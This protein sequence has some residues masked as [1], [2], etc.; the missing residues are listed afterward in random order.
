MSSL[1]LRLLRKGTKLNAGREGLVRT[2]KRGYP[3]PGP[4]FHRLEYTRIA[5]RI[6]SSTHPVRERDFPRGL[7]T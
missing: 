1:G 3:L 5:R 6:V 4:D 2:R 7:M